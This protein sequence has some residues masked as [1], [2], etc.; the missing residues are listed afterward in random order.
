MKVLVDINVLLDVLLDREGLAPA[1]KR[2]LVAVEGGRLAGA[3]SATA[4][5]TVHYLVARE[6]GAQAAIAAV[7]K[8]LV[9]FE[10]APVHRAVLGS[11]L[12]LGFSDYEDAVTHEAARRAGATA[13]VTRNVRHFRNAELAVFSPEELLGALEA[14]KEQAG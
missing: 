3:V 10:I 1:S 6:R 14:A 12:D 7:R 2:V 5:T 4:V 11:A 9:L 8:L 13:I